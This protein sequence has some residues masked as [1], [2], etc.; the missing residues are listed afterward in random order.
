MR[1]LDEVLLKMRTIDGK[2]VYFGFCFIFLCFT[3]DCFRHTQKFPAC[4]KDTHG[5]TM[6][7]LI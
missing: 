6:F 7:V 4:D 3:V 2:D 5:P 1:K